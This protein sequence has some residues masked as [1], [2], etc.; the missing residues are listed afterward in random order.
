MRGKAEGACVRVW[1]ARDRRR[2]VARYRRIQ[3]AQV[4]YGARRRLS[5]R[6]Y[7]SQE[8]RVESRESR[9][10]PAS[11]RPP[12]VDGWAVQE[13]HIA[14]RIS[15]VASRLEGAVT[16]LSCPVLSVSV[17]VNA[18]RGHAMDGRA[19]SSVRGWVVERRI[20]RAGESGSRTCRACQWPP[21]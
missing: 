5:A 2:C 16:V 20:G 4:T 9:V 19:A 18:G 6:R 12:A 11:Q 3:T 8:S 14:Y 17:R 10:V 21:T 7:Q 15:R 1:H 13:W